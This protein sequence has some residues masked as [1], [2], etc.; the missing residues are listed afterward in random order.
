MAC[1][2]GNFVHIF[3]IPNINLIL[4]ESMAGY[5]LIF[6]FRKNNRA[7]LTTSV[8]LTDYFFF[9]NIPYSKVSIL[10]TR[11]SRQ[12][13][14]L[15]L[16]PSQSFNGCGM[17]FLNQRYSCFWGIYEKFIIISTTCKMFSIR[18]PFKPTN[19]LFMMKITLLRF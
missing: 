12:N 13:I 18:R 4:T 3:K 19:F 8:L 2:S 17:S 16:R 15:S 6:S 1:K 7:Y 14:M 9:I 10:S 5:N 11:T